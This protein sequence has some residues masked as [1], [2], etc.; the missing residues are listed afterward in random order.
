VL[1][2]VRTESDCCHPKSLRSRDE[3]G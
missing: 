3:K 2:L 1:V